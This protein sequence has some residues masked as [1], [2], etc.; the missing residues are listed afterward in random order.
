MRMCDPG[1]RIQSDIM[2]KGFWMSKPSV[3]RLVVFQVM[4]CKVVPCQCRHM[5]RPQRHTVTTKQLQN[6]TLTSEITDGVKQLL[7][8][9]LR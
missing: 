7:E 6:A 1:T 8:S 9:L 4:N 3:D 2:V 5:E